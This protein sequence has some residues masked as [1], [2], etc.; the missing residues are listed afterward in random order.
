ML[1]ADNQPRGGNSLRELF[2]AAVFA[3]ACCGTHAASAYP[4][5]AIRLIVPF[6]PGGSSDV[7]SRILGVPLGS[8][9]GQ[10]VVVDNRP[11]ASGNL[12]SEIR[13]ANIKVD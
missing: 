2:A 4:S 12:G 3:F 9:L 13:Q 8:D 1:L 11:S 7:V 6:P 10:P 5:R